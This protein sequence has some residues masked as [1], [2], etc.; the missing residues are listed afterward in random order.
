MF[1]INVIFFFSFLKKETFIIAR[2]V[3]FIMIDGMKLKSYSPFKNNGIVS[4]N[5][6]K[7]KNVYEIHKWRNNGDKM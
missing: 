6:H 5:F 3:E 1:K 4:W 2:Y 7:L